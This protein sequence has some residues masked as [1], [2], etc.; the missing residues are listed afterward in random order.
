MIAANIMTIEGALPESATLADAAPLVND[1]GAAVVVGPGGRV[2]G[3]VTRETLSGRASRDAAAIPVVEVM[4]RGY[5]TIAPEAGFQAVSLALDGAGGLCA[6]VVVD[7]GH[8]F[9]GLI[10]PKDV[11]RRLWEYRERREAGRG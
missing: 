8:R 3:L 11:N 5:A 2:S 4:D 9:L 10:T 6:V 7:D 1:A